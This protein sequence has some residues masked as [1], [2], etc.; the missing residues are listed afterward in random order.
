[1]V[2]IQ[3]HFDQSCKNDEI[4]QKTDEKCLKVSKQKAVIFNKF[5]D[6]VST[7]CTQK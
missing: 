6:L 5:C 7:A 2:E 4:F 1:M 3:N